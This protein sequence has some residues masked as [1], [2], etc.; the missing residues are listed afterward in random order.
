MKKEE[1]QDRDIHETLEKIAKNEDEIHIKEHTEIGEVF[2][3]LDADTISEQS[4]MPMIDFNTR[5]TDSMIKAMAIFDE[6]K[7]MGIAPMDSNLTMVLKRLKVS[8]KGLG[9]KEKVQIAAASRSA[10]LSGK[11]GGVMGSLFTPRE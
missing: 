1:E 4:N 5:L 7:A 2:S 3:N 6:F 9:R 11:A 10:H 8:E